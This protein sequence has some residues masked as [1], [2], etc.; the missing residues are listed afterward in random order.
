MRSIAWMLR[1]D[2]KEF[3]VVQHLYAMRDEDLSSEA[4]VAAFLIKTQSKDIELAEKILDAWMAL[5]IE[6][7]VP[8]DAT[9]RDIDEVLNGQLDNL[10]YKFMYP[11]TTAELLSIH[12]K[13]NNYNDVDSLYQFIDGVNDNVKEL[14]TQIKDSL[15]QQFCR[16]RYGGKYNSS[17][18][19]SAIWF[20]V[21][22]VG[23]NWAN[24]IY[25][26]ANDAQRKYHIEYITICRD[27]ESDNGYDSTAPEYFYK[28]KDG[29]PYYNMPI[30]EFLQEE[31]EHSLVFSDTEL[32]SGVIRSC[33][34]ELAK[35][36]TFSETSNVL[37][38]SCI[39]LP[40]NVKKYIL[41]SEL[42]AMCVES[43]EYFDNLPTRTKRKLGKVK[44]MILQKYPEILQ[45]DID[46]E[47]MENSRGNLTGCRLKFMIESDVE[48]LDH[49]PIEIKSTRPVCDMQADVIFRLFRIEYED[50][51]KFMKIN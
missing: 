32:G 29:V 22:S 5:L 11:L 40:R 33:K 38:K 16:V 7:S 41:N 13:C 12:N 43:S 25:I 34:L 48:I 45:L 44:N 51:K 4:E 37:S 9:S 30:H 23:F 19:E 36:S 28:A 1:N 42:N 26:F 6:N 27:H 24:I 49:L 35:G 47:D 50:Y 10:P 21:S 3:P 39:E 31:H 17:D 14:Q 15:N 8:Y 20:R 18:G 2:G 46:H